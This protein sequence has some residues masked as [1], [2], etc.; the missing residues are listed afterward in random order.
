MLNAVQFNSIGGTPTNQ[1]NL[2]VRWLQNTNISD[3]VTQYWIYRWPNPTMAFTNDA[4]PSNYL[5]G[6]VSQ[7]GNSSLN[8]LL[9]TNAGAPMTPGPSNFWYSVR[10]V[11]QSACGQL[12]FSPNSAPVS[13]VLRQHAA[14]PATSGELVGSC[15]SPVV[16]FQ[17]F[18][19]PL[20]PNGPDTTN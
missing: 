17:Q 5:I 8:S 10:A 3:L 16:M 2:L 20:N 14:P 7:L 4:T 18:D 6:V 13:G 1:Q 19:T 11:S 15:G 9:D 12:L